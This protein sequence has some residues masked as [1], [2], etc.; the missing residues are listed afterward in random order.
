MSSS[1]NIPFIFKLIGNAVTVPLAT[2]F[3]LL[4]DED[5]AIDPLSTVQGAWEVIGSMLTMLWPFFML[6]G[7]AWRAMNPLPAI[8]NYNCSI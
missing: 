5:I 2:A 8:A 7:F 3:D 1:N 4:I 6:I